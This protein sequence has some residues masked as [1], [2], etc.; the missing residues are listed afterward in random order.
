MALAAN[1]ASMREHLAAAAGTARD[2]SGLTLCSCA[3]AAVTGLAIQHG[4][5]GYNEEGIYWLRIAM[6]LTLLGWLLP[7]HPWLERGARRLLPWFV[8]LCLA[9]QCCL[10]M[11]TTPASQSRHDLAAPLPRDW[12]FGGLGSAI[13]MALPL[14]RRPSRWL[15]GALLVIHFGLCV[16]VLNHV[17]NPSIDVVTVHHDAFVALLNGH[18][19]YAISIPNIYHSMQYYPADMADTTTLHTGYFYPPVSL[20]LTLPGFAFLGDYRLVLALACELGAL[21]IAWLSPSR[22][23]YALLACMLFTP[24]IFFLLC[25]GWTEP[26]MFLLACLVIA[27]HAHA[28]KPRLLPIALGLLATVKQYVF[29]LMPVFLLLPR[30]R[31]P[32]TR[33]TA[34]I[35]VQAIGVAA[36][37]NLPFFLWS[38]AAYWRSVVY[39]Q[40]HG[41][42]RAD[43]L[44]FAAEAMNLHAT[45]TPGWV[46]LA[47]LL[48]MM[49]LILWRAPR[50]VA[51][52]LLAFG[53]AL[54][55][56]LMYGRQAFANYYFLSLACHWAGAALSQLDNSP[57]PDL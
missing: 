21:L 31:P 26:V 54:M 11:M 2:R 38:P 51:G 40:T 57:A 39:F 33:A 55:A 36:L 8:G 17:P 47:C 16:L 43:A 12:Y 14:V 25:Y 22:M 50:T 5:G 29:L 32:A 37:V 10:L 41:P 3:A 30:L 46:P 15:F 45:V 34:R 18:N 56:L 52:A 44:S 23:A 13:A 6:G 19:P 20:M 49:A 48:A 42:F 9:G 28:A 1:L 53:A 7:A 24:R 4:D 27:A 35:V